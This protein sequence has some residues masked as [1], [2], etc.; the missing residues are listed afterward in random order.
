[1]KSYNNHVGVP[2]SLARMPRAT[3]YG[4]FEMGMNHAGRAAR[5]D[6]A[7]PARM[8]R[9]V[10]TIAPAHSEFFASEE[11]IADAKGEIFQGWSRTALPIIPYDSPPS[12]RG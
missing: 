2:L 6:P 10:T 8:S 7:G 12:R 5:T 4:V 1:M 3:K 9:M 11:A